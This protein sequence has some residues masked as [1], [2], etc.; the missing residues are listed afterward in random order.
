MKYKLQRS[1]STSTARVRAAKEL[2]ARSC[3]FPRATPAPATPHGGMHAGPAPSPPSVFESAN[4]AL[5]LFRNTKTCEFFP[6]PATQ[7][8]PSEKLS[9][10]DNINKSHSI[11]HTALK[12]KS[13]LFNTMGPQTHAATTRSNCQTTL[14]SGRMRR[15]EH[16]PQPISKQSLSGTLV[17]FTCLPLTFCYT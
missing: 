12:L 14:K 3:A 5:L 17:L 10:D 8:P 15:G 16:N 6:W 7:L 13:M 2:V 4:C 1:K 11:Q 9:K